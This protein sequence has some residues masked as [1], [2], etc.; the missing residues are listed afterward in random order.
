M[1]ADF[2]EGIEEL[3]YQKA[4]EQLVASINEFLGRG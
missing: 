2:V 3:V 4:T 1:R